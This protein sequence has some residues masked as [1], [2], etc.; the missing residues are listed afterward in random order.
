M[1]AGLAR[2]EVRLYR[3]SSEIVLNEADGMKHPCPVNLHNL[4]TVPQAHLGRRAA[5]LGCGTTPALT[6]SSPPEVFD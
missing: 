6:E 3:F 1:A 5:I 2:G 4:V